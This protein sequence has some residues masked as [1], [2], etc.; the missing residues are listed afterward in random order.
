MINR[1]N[2]PWSLAPCPDIEWRNGAPYSRQF[3]DIY[4]SLEDG[5]AESQYVFLD[6]VELTTHVAS[7]GDTDR[8]TLLETGFGTGLN[9]LLTLDYWLKNRSKGK[10]HYI[11]IDNW[12]LRRKDLERASESHPTLKKLSTRL[13]ASWPSPTRGCHRIR[14]PEISV[15]LDLWW[16]DAAD[17]LEDLTSRGNRWIDLWYLDG[18]APVKNTAIWSERV[19]AAMAKLSKSGARFSTFTA[20]GNVRRGLDSVHFLV[21]KRPGF[22]RKRECLTGIFK[23]PADVINTVPENL[24]PITTPWDLTPINQK[25]TTALIIGAGLAGASTAR[26]LAERGIHVLVLERNTIASGGSSQQQ[27]LTYTRLSRCFS[28][29]SD[30]SLTSY[31]YA[32]R[33]YQQQLQVSL[34]TNTGLIGDACGYLQLTDNSSSLNYLAEVL[35]NESG[36]AVTLNAAQALTQLG[37]SPPHEINATSTQHTATEPCALYF[38][39][40]LWLHLPSVCNTLLN[41][42]LIQVKENLG[43]LTFDYTGS[44]W[45]ARSHNGKALARELF[46]ADILVLCTAYD[47]TQQPWTAWLPLQGIRGQTTHIPATKASSKLKTALCHKGYLPPAWNGQHCLGASYGPND[48]NL[49]ERA[50]DHQHNLNM[51][52]RIL[53]SLGFPEQPHELQGNVG[54]R[55]A[56]ADHLPIAGPIPDREQFNANYPDLKK[57]KTHLTPDLCPMIP[58]LWALGGLGSRGL[59]T[60]PLAAELIASQIVNEPA[61]LPHYLQQAISPARFLIR[62]LI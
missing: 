4:F 57:Q 52:A 58:G 51:L 15:T 30:F 39:K 25:P 12:P 33:W 49:D 41:H 59:I 62:S 2:Q 21:S 19:F 26:S 55:C 23:Q 61:P 16:E 54:L 7:L 20:A 14:W 28:P 36:P 37:L 8:L 60:A 38:P 46:S 43:G 45:Q 27:G 9:F 5:I 10:L 50:E 44:C 34:S 31:E 3:N 24:P 47:L 35:Q 17:T 22:G 6:G 29:L 18:F 56:T 42:P 13:L 40:A 1:Q 32:T 48:H 53:P 11:G